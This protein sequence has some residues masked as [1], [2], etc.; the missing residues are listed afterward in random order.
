MAAAAGPARRLRDRCVSEPRG[1]ANCGGRPLPS[2]SPSPPFPLAS[3]RLPSPPPSSPPRDCGASASPRGAR[4]LAARR[5]R[6]GLRAPGRGTL[7]G[8]YGSGDCCDA[9]RL[10]VPRPRA[11]RSPTARGWGRVGPLATLGGS[12]SALTPVNLSRHVPRPGQSAT[13]GAG[14]GEAERETGRGTEPGT[15]MHGEPKGTDRCRRRAEPEPRAQA[16]ASPADLDGRPSP[17]PRAPCS[18]GSRAGGW[19]SEAQFMAGNQRSRD[20]GAWT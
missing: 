12:R 16:P 19:D 15:G 13:R 7:G 6:P 1:G 17:S 11:A 3:A 18:A 5:G 9:Q 8:R 20:R 10:G 4:P 2:L 14:P